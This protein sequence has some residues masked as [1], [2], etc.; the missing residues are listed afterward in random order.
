MDTRTKQ[1]YLGQVRTLCHLFEGHLSCL[2]KP[3]NIPAVVIDGMRAAQA[4]GIET[5]TRELACEAESAK[6]DQQYLSDK[7]NAAQVKIDVLTAELAE[8]KNRPALPLLNECE[9]LHVKTLKP[10]PCGERPECYGCEHAPEDMEP[11][12]AEWNTPGNVYQIPPRESWGIGS[13]LPS[14]DM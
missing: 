13:S 5:M 2:P 4:L 10:L 14:G 9:R 6:N 11:I 8:I 7:L 3:L 1:K 12:R